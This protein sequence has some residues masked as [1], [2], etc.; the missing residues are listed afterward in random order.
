MGLRDIEKKLF[1]KG[2]ESG[3]NPVSFFWEK[4]REKKAEESPF[5]PQ[6]L[7]PAKKGENAIWIKEDEERKR[8]K[9]KIKKIFLLVASVIACLL[10]LY[11]AVSL[12]R[13]GVFSEERVKVAVSS[14]EKVQSGEL[15]VFTIDYQN[16][17]S[18]SLREAVLHINFPENFKPEGNLNFQSE[19][20][21]TQRFVIGNVPGNT[22]GKITFQGKFFGPKDLLSYVNILF[23]YKSFNFSST[24][25]IEEKGGIL[26]TS[27]PLALELGGPREA[28][29]GNVVNLLAKY[30][31]TGE[32]PFRNL[33][34]KV[35][36][37]ADFSFRNSEP[38][39]ASENN[40]W[41]VGDLGPGESGE[42]RISG[43]V[44]GRADEIKRFKA[45]LGETKTDSDFLALS[46]SETSLKIVG[47][48]FEIE[49]TINGKSGDV[50]VN[51]GDHLE[52]NIKFKNASSIGLKDVILSEE[53]ASPILD[54]TRLY[55]SNS[56]AFLDLSKG[57]L[58]WKAAD[59][60]VLRLMSPNQTGEVGFSIPVREVIPVSSSNDKNFSISANAKIDSPDVPTPEGTNKTVASNTVNIR[61]NS[62]IGISAEGYYND[63][64]IK[65]SGPIPLQSGSETT[66]AIHLK[67]LNVSN[68]L[69]GAKVIGS[70]PAGVSWK[71]VVVPQGADVSFEGRTNE[72][73]WNVGKFPAGIGI[74]TN[75]RELVFQ[76]GV[77]PGQN[78]I[79][80]HAPLLGKTVFSGEDSFTGQRLEAVIEGKNTNLSED[81][82][83]GDAGGKVA[84]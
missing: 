79:G 51:A 17:N 71:G 10:V 34:L 20:V 82:S 9:Q 52:F 57:M 24:F 41:F 59:N 60:P 45:S 35:E 43:T 69:T 19:G 16:R 1:K 23:E 64:E 33:K 7:L 11:F 40:I 30:K 47:L 3:E 62:K 49:Q 74:I 76:V 25:T 29:S 18:V 77:T 38:L 12:I 55:F 70:L 53:I 13:R 65:N 84:Q 58:V 56:K 48:P 83:V 15:A 4:D 73:V 36:Y 39:P 22:G 61:L 54:Y 66:F 68:D 50:I 63:S 42:V 75:P 81:I 72:F 37:P 26:I 2:E 67:L 27:S 5:R 44:S 6:D 31:N 80:A 8:K 78:I 32:A 28:A 46:D 21:N 14:N